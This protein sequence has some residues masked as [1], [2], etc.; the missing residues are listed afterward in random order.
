MEDHSNYYAV[1]YL[2]GLEEEVGADGAGAGYEPVV[3]DVDV[4]GKGVDV[5]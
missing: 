3:G 5:F 2:A 4:V 1:Q